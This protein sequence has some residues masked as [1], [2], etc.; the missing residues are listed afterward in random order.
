[1]KI[2]VSILSLLLLLSAVSCKQKDSDLGP[3]GGS[4]DYGNSPRTPVPAELISPTKYWQ[5]GIL[6]ATNFYDSYN[7][8]YKDGAG[9]SYMFY[10][11]NED[12]TYTALLYLKATSSAG[13]TR[14]VWTETKGT[15]VVGETTLSNNVTYKTI[16]LHPV[17]GT[18][19][20]VINYGSETKKAL[21]QK[22]FDSRTLFKAKFAC[23]PFVNEYG[24]KC[25]D[26]LRID[27]DDKVLFNFHEEK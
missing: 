7:S 4:V 20:W 2:S 15:V 22:D 26:M 17:T 25:L 13:E 11:F 10:D 9:G 23:E 5:F 1:M 27:T 8:T 21:T 6:S 24:V 18:D 16:E 14:Q 12:G 19:R 3:D